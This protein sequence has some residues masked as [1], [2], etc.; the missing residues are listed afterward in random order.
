MDTLTTAQ[1]SELMSHVKQKDSKIELLVR[2]FL[3]RRGFRF[4]LH[5]RK[6]PGRP[7]LVLRK[8]KS[9]VFVN[10]CF[11][12]SHQSPTCKLARLPKSNIDFWTQKLTRN[13]KRDKKEREELLAM[14]WRV[15]Y[16]WEC[17]LGKQSQETLSKLVDDIRNGHNTKQEK[18]DG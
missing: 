16:V 18:S 9:V 6:L 1:R 11:W 13:V 3:R 4:S 7:D 14:G 15:F 17:Q 5:S 8:Y 10:G 12:H 2:S